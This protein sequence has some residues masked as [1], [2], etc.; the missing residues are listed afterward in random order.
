MLDDVILIKQTLAGEPPA[1]EQLV[2]RYKGA[3]LALAL[4]Y[5]QN[6]YD[7]QDIVQEA[8][9]SAYLHL[10]KLTDASRFKPWLLQIVINR[11]RMWVR[12]QTRRSQQEETAAGDRA[13][14][15]V[16]YERFVES[17]AWREIIEKAMGSL[18]PSDQA[19]ATFYF[20]DDHTCQ[21]VASALGL[22]AGT[23]RRRL[24]GIRRILGKEVR[25]M[26]NEHGTL[27]Y[28]VGIET[29]GGVFTTFFDKGTSLPAQKTY[30]FTTAKDRQQ[31]VDI[32]LVE[33]DAD[34]VSECR[35]LGRIV[36]KDFSIGPRGTP[37]IAITFSIERDGTLSIDAIEKK[38]QEKQLSIEAK[39]GIEPVSVKVP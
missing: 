7:A 13:D 2:D 38:P 34:L 37:Q 29:L 22:P 30:T 9:F 12:E 14:A 6:L 32:H 27:K 1:F 19:I 24:C 5:V 36:G 31:E 20:F 17:L 21:E 23:V 11:A 33:G 4:Q 16:E 28:R 15:P 8:L 3:A 26:L 10:P 35:S 18:S 25:T 39:T